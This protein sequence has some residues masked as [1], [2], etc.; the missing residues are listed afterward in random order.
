MFSLT[1]L[2]IHPDN[3]FRIGFAKVFHLYQVNARGQ[4]M[5]DVPSR[6]LIGDGFE[7][8]FKELKYHHR[9]LNWLHFLFVFSCV[10]AAYA[11]ICTSDF[12]SVN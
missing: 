12:I 4:A 2:S 5:S 3:L 11:L 6:L 1:K 9:F 10:V 7:H 8:R